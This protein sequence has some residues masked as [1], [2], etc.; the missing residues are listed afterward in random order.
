M[1]S[2]VWRAA[3]VLTAHVALY[4]LVYS[5]V[6]AILDRP[7]FPP[8]ERIWRVVTTDLADTLPAHFRATL[9]RWVMVF[10]TGTLGGLVA[11]I[12]IGHYDR[13][14]TWLSVDI[15][16]LRSLPATA[17]IAFAVAALGDNEIARALP[18]FY[19]TFLTL[20]FYGSKHVRALNRTRIAHL[21]DLGASR[22]F[23]LTRCVIFELLSPLM[24]GARQAISLSFLVLISVELVIGTVD[25]VGLGCAI[26]DYKDH[27][28]FSHV[29]GTLLAI[30]VSGYALNLVGR[31]VHRSLVRWERVD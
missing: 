23:V 7:A 19:I 17:L 31:S 10:L 8:V 29:I 4:V 5:G 16:F 14:H 24:F 1:R 22:F 27:L 18:A 15:D 13:L 25:N 26:Y 2:R 21:I 20:V 30:G 9:A 11:G 6:S 3:V 28:K 12:L